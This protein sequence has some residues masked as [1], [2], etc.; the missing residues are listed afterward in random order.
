MAGGSRS[1][2]GFVAATVALSLIAAQSPTFAQPQAP[3][4]PTPQTPPAK[5]TDEER[6]AARAAASAGVELLQQGRYAEALD[7]FQRAESLVHAP[8]HLL[9]IARTQVKLGQ[10]VA[11][12]ETYLKVTRE[13]LPS[14]APRAFVD[15]QAAAAQEEKELEA[16]IPTLLIRAAGKD[17]SDVTVTMDGM[18]LPT[19]MIGM[20]APVDP[21]THA[22]R[23]MAKDGTTAELQVKLAPGSHE[24]AVLQF[25]GALATPPLSPA[26]APGSAEATSPAPGGETVPP[27]S[28]LGVGKMLGW[29][30]V[31]VGVVG[32]AVGTTF[33]A[34]NRSKRTDANNLYLC[35]NNGKCD[36]GEKAQI[37]S[38]DQQADNAATDAWIGYVIGGAALATGLVL[39]FTSGEA[40]K[41]DASS[42]LHPWIGLGAGGVAGAF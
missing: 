7:R 25:R 1:S 10:L 4:G 30:G 35:N 33:V 8:T 9:Y 27:A 14:D 22:L 20:S 29:I 12:S 6:A 37:Q 41:T 28:G 31:G 24:T 18:A 16:R 32:I 2:R 23:A 40:K 21:G 39:L 3:T 11:A 15:A 17:A 5:L 19:A 13:V 26:P 36:P 34:I 38:L 42:G